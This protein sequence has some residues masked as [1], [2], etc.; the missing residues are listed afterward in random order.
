MMIGDRVNES[1]AMAASHL[2]LR[3]ALQ[4]HEAV[5]ALEACRANVV[6]NS[7]RLLSIVDLLDQAQKTMDLIS[8][9]LWF[10]VL[11]N[12][13]ALF[14]STVFFLSTGVMLSP[15]VGV[16]LMMVQMLYV[17]FSSCASDTFV[18]VLENFFN[19]DGQPSVDDEYLPERAP[20]FLSHVV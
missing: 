10:S 20:H 1:G 11:Y 17:F 14:F 7:T 12:V 2:S 18:S 6:L 19:S 9:N 8:H 16:A 4:R 13:L 15:G 3:I 5:T